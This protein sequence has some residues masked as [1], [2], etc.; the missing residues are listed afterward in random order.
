MGNYAVPE[1]IRQLKPRGTMVKRIA[2][3][4]YVYEYRSVKDETGKRKTQMGKVIGVIKEGIGFVPNATFATSE[5]I[6]TV[7]FGEYAVSLA[8]STQTLSKLKEV[9]NPLDAISIY[10]VALIHVVQ[11]FVY[12]KDVERYYEMSVLSLRYPELKLGYK[13]LSKL[14]D[15]L[16][17]RQN[18]VLE[19]QQRLLDQSS[20]QIA[21]DGHVIAD[22][23]AD[24]DLAA[25]GYKFQKLGERQINLL[26]AYDVNTFTPVLSRIYD[27]ANVDK[28]SVR[29]LIDQV[30]IENVLFIVDRGFYSEEN[31]DLFTQNGNAYI[32]PLAKNLTGCKKAVSHLEMTSRFVFQKGRK[33]TVV[34]YKDEIIEGRRI[35]TYRD[36]NESATE[37]ANYLR[38]M[39]LGEKSY[40]QESFEKNKDLMGVTVLQTSLTEEKFDAVTVYGLY[41]K[42]WAIENFFNYFKNK[43]DYNTFYQQDYYKVQGLSFIMLVSALI[44]R[45]LENAVV[46]IKGKSLQD[47]LLDARMVKANKRHG[48]WTVCNCRAKQVKLFKELRTDLVVIDA[49]T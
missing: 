25:K 37:Q 24:N 43:A 13:A 7:E 40:T 46:A 17:R 12:M 8:N 44:Y 45:E 22:C 27:G 14:Y 49:P 39:A 16:G 33:S 4:Y 41:K 2:G 47:C 48:K 28:V 38:H 31:I 3:H 29:D 11:G 34:E 18:S 32:I 6:T 15:K 10:V 23:S 26:M 30:Q 9:F 19:F 20:R 5:E 21:I 42:R 35:V 36:L 1:S